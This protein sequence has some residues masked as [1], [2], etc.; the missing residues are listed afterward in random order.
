MR[1]FLRDS[2]RPGRALA[3]LVC[4]A[5]SFV[6]VVA[7]APVAAATSGN[8]MVAYTR[9]VDADLDGIFLGG[10]QEELTTDIYMQAADAGREGDSGQR[11]EQDSRHIPEL[12]PGRDKN[13]LGREC[14]R[15]VRHHGQGPSNRRHH[16]PHQ[17]RR[18]CQRAL[19][20]LVE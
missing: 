2:P 19:A 6:P 20:E 8:G 11:A 14:L 10:S 13:C 16:Q 1:N 17:D 12:L 15:N 9:G 3:G 4:L 5:A 7:P 18:G